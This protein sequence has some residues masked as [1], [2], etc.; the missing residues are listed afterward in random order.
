MPH[1]RLPTR[2]KTLLENNKTIIAIK[3]SI[4]VRSRIVI[5]YSSFLIYIY[6]NLYSPGIIGI[7]QSFGLQAFSILGIL[8]FDRCKVD[9]NYML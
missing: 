9:T 7:E 2:S 3:T 6:V 5:R 8:I 1:S 4:I